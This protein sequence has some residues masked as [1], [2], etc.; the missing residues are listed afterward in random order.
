MQVDVLAI[1]AHPDDIELT[2]GGTLAKLA[3]AGHTVGLVDLTEGEMGT[4]GTV[5]IRAKEAEKASRILGSATRR[6]LRI[7]DGNIELSTAN[8]MK[9][10][11]VIR[12]LRPKLLLFP[13]SVERHPDHVRAHLLSKESWFYSG[14]EKIQTTVDGKKQDPHR[15]RNFFEYMQWYEFAPS[16]VVDIT[17][18]YNI[19][20][21]SVQAHASQFHRPESKERETLLSSPDFMDKID[22]RAR[23]YGQQ[24]GVRYGEPFY[25][26]VPLGIKSMFDLV[27][28][29]G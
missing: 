28:A 26:F 5:E 20:M 21:E 9:L 17:E 22:A 24:I 27:I 15:P 25:S 29:G 14:L 19:K 4:R 2:C 13:H 11:E 18:T 3:K 8:K 10:I 1:G 23:Y 12:E 6:N 16:F 7:P